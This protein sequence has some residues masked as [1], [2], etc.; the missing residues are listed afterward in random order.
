METEVILTNIYDK[1]SQHINERQKRLLVA[2]EAESYGYGGVTLLSNITGMSRSTINIG[3]KELK[4]G[5]IFE[6]GRI[7]RE[8]AGRKKIQ[9]YNPKL[10][11]DLNSLIEPTSRG[12]P[13]S[14]LRW[15]C[16][17]TRKLAKE[18]QKKGHQVSHSTVAMLLKKLGYSLQGA[19]KTLG[20]CFRMQNL[21]KSVI[22]EDHTAP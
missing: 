1:L 22:K 18:L 3:K 14:P 19:K 11:E 2:V 5:I 6:T 12:D 9:K 20:G 16:L 21:M 13:E 4:E 10:E 8:G 17:S 15:T 7:R